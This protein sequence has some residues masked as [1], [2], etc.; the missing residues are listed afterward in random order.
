MRFLN[1]G[2][3]AEI[4]RFHVCLTEKESRLSGDRVACLGGSSEPSLGVASSQ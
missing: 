4:V 3:L 1:V 2:I